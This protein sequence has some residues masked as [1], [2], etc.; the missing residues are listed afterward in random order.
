[1]GKLSIILITGFA[2]MI[3]IIVKNNVE[4]THASM[5]NMLTYYEDVMARNIAYSAAE[6]V[7]MELSLNSMYHTDGNWVIKQRH[8]GGIDSTRITKAA[9]SSVEIDIHARFGDSNYIIR[10]RYQLPQTIKPA[11]AISFSDED[12]DFG[13]SGNFITVD[14]R[15]HNLNKQL[16]SGGDVVPAVAVPTQ[17]DANK[18]IS[19]MTDK[20]HKFIGLGGSPS[21]QVQDDIPDVKDIIDELEKYVDV[22][23]QASGFSGPQ[24]FGT[25]PNPQNT[26]IKPTGSNKDV[27]FSGGA[28]ANGMLVIDGNLSVSGTLMVNGILIVKG[29]A[30]FSGPVTVNGLILIWQQWDEEL[31]FSIS[32]NLVNIL[33][34]VVV[35][36]AGKS[37]KFDLST[38][39]GRIKYSNEAI[40]RAIELVGVKPA[41]VQLRWFEQIVY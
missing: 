37:T 18:A 22:T 13:F 29:S 10:S 27:S 3:G 28:T 23:I 26:L 6:E 24:T 19:K 4:R 40:D 41:F 30:E 31:E 12:I 36:G 11:A 20:N 17:Q 34:A 33:G 15:D 39:M 21:V 9:K 16:I 32:G 38:N 2:I 8:I 25:N 1:M 35:S 14:G 5:I 7:L